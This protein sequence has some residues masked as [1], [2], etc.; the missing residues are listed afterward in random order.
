[1]TRKLINNIA[2]CVCE[3]VSRDIAMWA[4]KVRGK[5]AHPSSI[6]QHHSIDWGLK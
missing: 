4:R 2:V 1:L 6:G 5:T 3:D